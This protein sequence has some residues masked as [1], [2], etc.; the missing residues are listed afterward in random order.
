ML[1][2]DSDRDEEEGGE[3]C[4]PFIGGV[5]HMVSV[6]SGNHYGTEVTVSAGQCNSSSKLQLS[7]IKLRW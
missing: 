1:V 2:K 4:P 3:L 5:G 7:T 6:G